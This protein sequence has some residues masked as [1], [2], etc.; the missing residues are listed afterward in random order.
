[1][2]RNG[3]NKELWFGRIAGFSGLIPDSFRGE[4]PGKIG[5]S[6]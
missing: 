2:A 1:M 5:L 3:T 6:P 4:E